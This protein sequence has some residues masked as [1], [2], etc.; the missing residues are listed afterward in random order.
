M[1]FTSGQ[2]INSKYNKYVN[3]LM[4]WRLKVQWK[5]MKQYKDQRF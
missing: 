4:C 1:E 3:Y 5:K 2:S